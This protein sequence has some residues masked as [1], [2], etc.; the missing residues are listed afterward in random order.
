MILNETCPQV[1]LISYPE[2]SMIDIAAKFCRSS[3][4]VNEIVESDY[5]AVLV[6]HIISSGHLAA[7]EFDWWVFGVENVSRV[8][9][10]Q[11]VRKRL[12]SYLIA[13]GR[14]DGKRKYE[15]TI[16]KGLKEN[17]SL[18][19]DGM[20]L[21]EYLALGE[22][23][24]NALEEKGVKAEDCRYIKPQATTTKI[25]IGMNTHSL[26]DWFRIRCCNRAQAE[27][28]SLANKMLSLCKEKQPDVF[29][30]AGAACVVDGF[31]REKESCG[32]APQR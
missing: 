3:K 12:A 24:Y 21:E 8:L 15:L 14:H 32:R 6:D 4:S 5:S 27:I 22:K 30:N 1:T 23:F 20:N 11:L 16:P 28:R 26:L 29:A 13:S 9:E 25:L 31:C 17:L 19:V 7:T 18:E 2:R 10:V